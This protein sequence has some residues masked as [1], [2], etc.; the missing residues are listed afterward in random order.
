M[1]SLFHLEAALSEV[2]SS[3]VFDPVRG[4][5]WKGGAA[6]PAVA[7]A[8]HI[9][10]LQARGNV[11]AVLQQLA[12]Q[13]TEAPAQPEP[14]LPRASDLLKK[15]A[16]RPQAPSM[17]PTHD[18]VLANANLPASRTSSPAPTAAA[19]AGA[20]LQRSLTPLSVGSPA[21]TKRKKKGALDTPPLKKGRSTSSIGTPP[22]S[23]KR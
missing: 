5:Q 17:P 23:A 16:G 6:E 21:A 4:Y 8:D 2:Y 10:T 3:V 20:E 11:E 14:Q 1:M 9:R 18:T 22:P 15:E 12:E 13:P 7:A 19:I